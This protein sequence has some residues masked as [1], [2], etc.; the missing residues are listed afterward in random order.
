M[1]ES[2]F[3]DIVSL[4]SV[5]DNT[6]EGLMSETTIEQLLASYRAARGREAY[7]EMLDIRDV[8]VGRL[9][10]NMKDA[11]HLSTY[12]AV[13]YEDAMAAIQRAMKLEGDDKQ[14]QLTEAA[15][16]VRNSRRH[17][18]AA[19]DPISVLFAEMLLGGHILPMQN[20][21]RSAIAILRVALADTD[22]LR[23]SANKNRL[24]RVTMNILLHLINHTID[25]GAARKDELER[26]EG[27]L[28]EN[29]IYQQET[30]SGRVEVEMAKLHASL[31]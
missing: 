8:L 27:R 7:T 16:W 19:K 18:E 12:S 5:E 23:H 31:A 13:E 30:N 25:A 28:K 17:A 3:C 24:E 15:Y 22:R 4:A 9:E 29:P 1:T 26:W 14:A 11:A 2:Y 10:A 21:L 20:N 6:A